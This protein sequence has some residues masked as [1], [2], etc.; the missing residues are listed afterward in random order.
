MQYDQSKD[1]VT[2]VEDFGDGK[3]TNKVATAALVFMARGIKE[4]WKQPLGYV[5][6][7]EACPSEVIK[8]KLFEIIDELTSMGLLIETIVSDLGSNFQKLLRELNVTPEKPW[9]L[10]KGKKIIYLFDPPH[11]IKAIRNNLMKHDFHFDEKIASW[12]DIEVVYERDKQ[13]T[14][15]C[16]PKLT[17]KHIHPN[18]FQKM[19][20]KLATQVV[21][22]TVASTVCMYISL[23]ALP[24]SAVGTAELIAKF[25]NIFD[26]LNSSNL[27]STKIYKRAMSKESS[28]HEFITD[29]LEFIKSIRV[30][31]RPTQEDVTNQLRCLKGL[32]MTLNGVLALWKHL[33]EDYALLFLMTRRL[34]QDPLENFFGLI[35]QQGANSDNPTPLQFTRAFRK[36]FVDTFLT[37]L[38]SGNC[39][40]DFDKFLIGS[41]SYKKAAR[42]EAA[43]KDLPSPPT[44]QHVDDTDFNTSD[45]EKNLLSINALTYVAG[46]LLKKCLGK[47]SCDTC[48]H[49]FTTESI[50]ERSQLF[51]FFKAFDNNKNCGGLT[52]PQ[53]MFVQHVSRM[54]D[55]FIQEFNNCIQRKNI[56]TYLISKMPTLPTAEL[57]CQNFPVTY[58]GKLFIKMRLHYALK[59]GNQELKT[60]KKSKKYMK[61]QHL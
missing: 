4:N 31:N 28:H 43:G 11:L 40:E 59:F 12:D 50:N 39:A 51:C 3:R 45:V 20:V 60:K 58:L 54:E 18:G 48:Y 57:K 10:H 29:M 37:P 5:L 49:T 35:R 2:G 16:C 7:H 38:P 24:P 23:G 22:Q 42:N 56:A 41:S 61:V 6:V 44:I 27:N 53:D 19:K 33:S 9:F 30:I 14:L 8:S 1:E 25:D 46:Y 55:I 17:K 26:C 15:R 32:Q 47:H 36:L 52:V 34:N 13:Q 21:S